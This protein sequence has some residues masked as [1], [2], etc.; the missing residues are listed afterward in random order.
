M[1]VPRTPK[2]YP[3]TQS[4]L[5][6]SAPESMIAR[7]SPVSISDIPHCEN[8]NSK[9][10]GSSLESVKNDDDELDL[11]GLSEQDVIDGLKEL[12]REKNGRDVTENE[13]KQWLEA[14]RG[15]DIISVAS[16]AM[17]ANNVIA[18]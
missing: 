9:N 4:T 15:S 8:D 13:V 12:F 18:V 5:L 2:K 14:I 6:I 7:Q 16:P 1:I 11:T 3:S 17:V 10:F